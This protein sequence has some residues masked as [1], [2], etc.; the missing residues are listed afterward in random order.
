MYAKCGSE[1]SE[2]CCTLL[3]IHK[4]ILAMMQ[5]KLDWDICLLPGQNVRFGEVE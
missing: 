4:Y 2:M 5:P 3:P 1:P